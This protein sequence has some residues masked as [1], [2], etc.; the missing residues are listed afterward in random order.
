MREERV[1]EAATWLSVVSL[2]Y[3]SRIESLLA[4]H[5]LTFGQLSILHHIARPEIAGGSRISEI[6]ASVALKQPAVTKAVA[7]FVEKGWLRMD[8]A[9]HDQ[10]ARRVT[11]TPRGLQALNDMHRDMSPDLAR[12]FGHF[13]PEALE[14]FVSHLKQLGIWLDQNRDTMMSK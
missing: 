7:K 6:A 12:V 8:V 3:G 5:G 13:K 14:I 10:R 11:V 4:R 2:L 9:E 1:G